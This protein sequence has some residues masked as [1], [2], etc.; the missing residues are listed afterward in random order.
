MA[1]GATSIK[2]ILRIRPPHKEAGLRVSGSTVYLDKNMQEEVSFLFDAA[3]KSK[4]TQRDIYMEVEPYL[5]N[6]AQGINTSILAY[7]ATGSGKTHTMCGTEEDPGIIPMM[8][9]ALFGRY[10]DT[11]SILFKVKIEMAYIEIYN[12]KVYDLLAEDLASLPV[13]E[14]AG[15]R[16]VV[17]G[18]REETVQD[19]EEFYK[20]FQKGGQRRKH[21]KTLLNTESS[22]SHAIVTLYIT[23]STDSSMVRTKI[24]LVDLA[25]SENNKRTGNEGISMVESA[26]IN[27]S[28]FVLNKVIESL[29]RGASRVP[30]RDS[31]L[32]R[33]LQD[34]LGGLSDCALIVNIRG[35]ASA[36]TLSTLSFA[37]KSRKVKL[38]PQSEKI[39]SNKWIDIARKQSGPGRSMH[40]TPQTA[41]RDRGAVPVYLGNRAAMHTGKITRDTVYRQNRSENMQYNRISTVLPKEDIPKT[42][43]NTVS[44]K[45]KKEKKAQSTRKE[46]F[47][48]ESMLEI[49][50][51]RDF[52]RVKSLPM[53]GDQRAEK[54]IKYT[55]IR[56]ITD[57]NEL[58]K[59]GI[60]EKVLMKLMDT[61]QAE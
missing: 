46:V 33:I 48:L 23:L 49:V 4:S 5:D 13:R 6:I 18:M 8:A 29:G 51:S 31:K 59:A 58:R 37:G 56:P 7:G 11:L 36:E 57:I 47:T 9:G 14:D 52:L 41:K 15:G 17:Q 54:I 44:G 10:K 53:I 3:Y 1:N 60:T 22:R 28:L 38:K 25:G 34:S 40:Y 35:D 2:T 16:V 45:K 50:N 12:E 42:E 27:R 30:Y 55:Q 20:L 43:K 26:S 24:N 19:E 39:A 61:V 21:R 32:T